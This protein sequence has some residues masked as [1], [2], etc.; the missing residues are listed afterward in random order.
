V[1]SP[2]ADVPTPPDR[3]LSLRVFSVLPNWQNGITERL[4]YMTEM[5]GSETDVEQRRT[6]RRYPRRSFEAQFARYG[7][8]RARLQQF[9]MS[10]GND[11]FLVPLWHEQFR[12]PVDFT[13]TVQFPDS[14]AEREFQPGT[15]AMLQDKRPDIYDVLTVV[16]IDPVANS[17]TFAAPNGLSQTWLA[18]SRITPLRP[19]RLTDLPALENLTDRVGTVAMRFSLTDPDKWVVPAWGHCGQLFCFKI[20]RSSPV[21][22][23]FERLAYTTDNE[24]GRP[25][26][27]DPGGRTRYVQQ[28]RLTLRGRSEVYSYR[29][30][31]AQARGRAL[32]FWMPTM[33]QDLQHLGDPTGASFDIQDIDLKRTFANPQ[34]AATTIGI[35]FKDR[36]RPAIYRNVT[37]VTKIAGGERVFVD[38]ALPALESDEIERIS[39]IAPSRFEQDAFELQHLV[40]DCAAVQTTVVTRTSDLG[41]DLP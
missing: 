2:D 18:G 5:L 39:F 31:L 6:L 11:E 22:M 21:T 13:L 36:T 38:V 41:I 9:L 20:D 3:L 37:Q 1:D 10:C 15:L 26:V 25:S 23:N 19:A 12:L 27:T 17:V 7:A 4:E 34:D 29:A 35:I 30:F 24:T 33:T 40:D 16:S 8:V 28:S 14:V 32:R